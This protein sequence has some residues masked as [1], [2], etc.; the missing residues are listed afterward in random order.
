MSDTVFGEGYAALY[1]RLYAEKD[2]RAE[3]DL[4]E[5]AR[6]RYSHFGGIN[7]L[8]IGCGTARHAVE[9]ASRGW[10]V[11]GVD[12][13]TAMLELARARAV[14]AGLDITFIEG[15]AQTFDA[16][17][18][19][20][21]A[22][23][24]FAVIGYLHEAEEVERALVNV[25]HHLKPG[26]LLMFDCWYGPAVLAQRPEERTRVIDSSNGRTTRY[27]RASLDPSRQLVSVR[28]RI[29]ETAGETLVSETAEEHVMRYFFDDELRLLLRDAGF[30]TLSITA[31]PS[32]DQVVSESDWSIFVVAAAR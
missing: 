11:T 2:Y 18:P 8:D 27:A 4:V 1:D 23:M 7:L 16:T 19:F 29:V 26:G 15:D 24:M 32:L 13:S 9:F 21:V 10:K 25:R 20:D 12:R 6:N 28:Y 30:R 22:L 3:C 14:A 31:F 5:S 17:G